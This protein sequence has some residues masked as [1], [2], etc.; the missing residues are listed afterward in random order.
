MACAPPGR[1]R[2]RTWGPQEFPGSG[3]SPHPTLPEPPDPT[4]A[5]VL[6]HLPSV[7]LWGGGGAAPAALTAQLRIGTRLTSKALQ[8]LPACQGASQRPHVASPLPATQGALSGWTPGGQ[9][10]PRHLPSPG[11]LST[12]GQ[13]PCSRAL[14]TSEAPPRPPER[15]LTLHA[16]L[17]Q[18]LCGGQAGLYLP[19]FAH[20]EAGPQ[21]AQHSVGHMPSL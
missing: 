16:G 14:P 8:V 19:Q 1:P 21:R 5:Q 17:A 18:G 2:L 11:S 10:W 15:D 9:P 3:A 6:G 13:S 7:G 12:A 20:P 4:Q